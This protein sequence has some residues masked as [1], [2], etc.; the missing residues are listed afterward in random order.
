LQ[1]ACRLL[2]ITG[3]GGMGKTR[4]ALAAAR[5]ANR[6]QAVEFLDGWFMSH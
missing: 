5:H 4:L 3:F 6:E 2:T 1:P